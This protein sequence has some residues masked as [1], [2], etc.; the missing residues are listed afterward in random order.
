M[1]AGGS[2]VCSRFHAPRRAPR[3]AARSLIA[4]GNGAGNAPRQ[5]SRAVS[6]TVP[7]LSFGTRSSITGTVIAKSSGLPLLAKICARAYQLRRTGK[8]RRRTY[9]F[10]RRAVSGRTGVYR[11]ARLVPGSYKVEF[12]GCNRRVSYRTTWFSQARNMRKA[13]VLK[14][15]PGGERAQVDAVMARARSNPKRRAR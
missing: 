11:I 3:R 7:K 5:L 6:V 10:A 12:T 8:A 4:T 2:P 9:V 1:P 14:L 13:T 15:A